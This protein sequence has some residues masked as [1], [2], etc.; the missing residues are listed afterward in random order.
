M[1]RPVREVRA[2]SYRMVLG[3]QEGYRGRTRVR[4]EWRE[5]RAGVSVL[6]SYH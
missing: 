1:Q 3:R 4:N 6:T 5:R 2:S